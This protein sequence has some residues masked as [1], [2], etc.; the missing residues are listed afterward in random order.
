MKRIGIVGIGAISGIYL[1]N[2][3]NMFKEIEIIGVCD[4]IRERAENAVKKY[5][6]PKLY[7]NMHELFADSEVDIV[8]NL[9]RP[10]EHYEVSRAALLAGKPVYSEKPLGASL[11]EGKKLVELAE[12][13][14]LWIAGAPDTYM[15]AGIQTCRKLIDEGA[16]G[17]IVGATACFACRGHESWHPDP[18]FYYK[19][20]GGPML[21]MGPYYI[22]ALINLLGGVKR[23]NGMTRKTFPTRTITSQPFNGTVVDVDVPTTIFGV[24]EFESGAIGSIMTSFDVRAHHMPIIEIYGS[25]GT[26]WV[27]DPNGFGGPVKLLK[28]GEGE[29]EIPVEFP[30][31]GNSRALG[32]AEMA[33]ALEKGRRPRASYKQT[34]HVL[35]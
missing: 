14:G 11:E 18:A 24:M 34:L 20:G 33:S 19:Y 7:E 2:I 4:L 3:T 28:A 32:L 17:T 10:Y 15:G 12:E 26:L 22:T 5:N 31:P 8:L 25:E 29:V 16:I 35:E 30:Y 13:K 23:L 1:E 27:P 6:I 9:T 21:D